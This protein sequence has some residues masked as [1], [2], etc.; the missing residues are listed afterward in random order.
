MLQVHPFSHIPNGVLCLPFSPTRD[1]TWIV[2][3]PSDRLEGWFTNFHN[4]R[5]MCKWHVTEK[6][7]THFGRVMHSTSFLVHQPHIVLAES[8]FSCNNPQAQ[9]GFKIRVRAPQIQI[10]LKLNANKRTIE[11]GYAITQLGRKSQEP[12]AGGGHIVCMSRP[13]QTDRN[14]SDLSRKRPQVTKWLGSSL[15]NADRRP[16]TLVANG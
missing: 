2:K 9:H 6:G 11:V 15:V 13:K 14:Q 16:L 1:H 8:Q 3:T 12:P 10:R 5:K 7:E 4:A